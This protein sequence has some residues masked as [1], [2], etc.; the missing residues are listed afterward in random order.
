MPVQSCLRFAPIDAFGLVEP[1]SRLTC[2]TRRTTHDF[3]LQRSRRYRH[4]RSMPGPHR[5]LQHLSA[6]RPAHPAP[7]CCLCPEPWYTQA[8]PLNRGSEVKAVRL[9]ADQ[10]RTLRSGYLYVLLDNRGS[11]RPTKSPPRARCVSFG[12]TRSLAKSPGPC[13]KSVFNRITIFP[14]H[15]STSKPTDT[16]PP[17]WLWPTTPGPRVC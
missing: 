14:R 5:H 16:P 7:A 11:G 9:R 6:K 17:G 8:L 13:A 12:P 10:P 2:L 1:A 4:Q 15:S 3:Q